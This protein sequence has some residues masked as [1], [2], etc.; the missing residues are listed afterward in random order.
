MKRLIPMCIGVALAA[1]GCH[2]AWIDSPIPGLAGTEVSGR[3]TQYEHLLE[4][5]GLPVDQFSRIMYRE[6]RCNPGAR[7]SSSGAAGL[8][9]IMPQWVT[10]WNGCTDTMHE[11]GA[12]SV[13]ALYDA[14]W[15]IHM[16]KRIYDLQG[17]RAWAQTR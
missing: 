14:G 3:C 7:N 17:T 6:S 10:R 4:A 15:N 1:S 8:L 12:C 13:D 11:L 9:Q 2:I 5:N 16:A